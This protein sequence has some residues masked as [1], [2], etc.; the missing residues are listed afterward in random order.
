VYSRS[1]V[2]AAELDDKMLL[3]ESANAGHQR[4]SVNARAT[5]SRAVTAG[6][7]PI[8]LDLSGIARQFDYNLQYTAFAE[9]IR[10][11][12]RILNNQEVA[13][14]IADKVGEEWLPAMRIIMSHVADPGAGGTTDVI[15]NM[16]K[17]LGSTA[18]KFILGLNRS[19]GVKQVFSI[20]ALWVE[21]GSWAGG[22]STVIRNPNQAWNDMLEESPFMRQRMEGTQIDREVGRVRRELSAQNTF[23][24]QVWEFVDEALFAFIRMFDAIAT[25]P[26]YYG[27]KKKME[28]KYG[29]GAQAIRETE[30]IISDTQPVSRAV[31]MSRV[32]LN[33]HGLARLMTLFTGFTMKFENR[34]RVYVR[35]WR[36]GKISTRDFMTHVMLERILPP[37][38]MNLLFTLGY[39]DDIEPE[40]IGWDILLYQLCG[41][42]VV[43][44]LVVGVSNMVR[45]GTDED[46]RGFSPIGTPLLATYSAIER[47]TQTLAR[48]FKGDEEDSEAWL[49]VVEAILALKGVPAVKVAREMDES[50][51]QFKHSKGLDAAFKLVVKPDPKERE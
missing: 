42:P 27:T 34:K 7:M 2:R 9:V 10:D 45:Q 48:W 49:A 23:S 36:E 46:F 17:G 33:R 32:Q 44:E 22:F 4:A 43:R 40:D 3:K 25:F 15:S 18:S 35:G 6:G 14:E 28:R 39:G 19:V 29:P 24:T 26:A 50:I 47:N 37:M 11:L 20:P 51:R 8:R 38:M 5:K 31:D 21:G 41:F 1:N 12:S 30:K 16:L 13:D